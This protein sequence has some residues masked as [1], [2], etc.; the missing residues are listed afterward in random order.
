MKTQ[1]GAKEKYQ[2]RRTAAVPTSP[3]DIVKSYADLGEN[4]FR[5]MGDGKF[6][7]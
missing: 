2:R 7:A 1:D 3:G 5:R 6:E 4:L